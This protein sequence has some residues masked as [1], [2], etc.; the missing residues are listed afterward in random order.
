MR[1]E[2]EPTFLFYGLTPTPIDEAKR[3]LEIPNCAT[4]IGLRDKAILEVFY[5]SGIR[6]EEMTR[7][8]LADVDS[9]NGFLRVNQGK[10]AKDRVVPLGQSA[11]DCV[12]RYI[13]Q[14]R[15]QWSPPPRN[16]KAL[17]LSSRQPH[18]PLKSQVIE[19]MVRQLGRQAG[20][21][22]RVTPHL[23]RHT[24]ATHLVSSG[25]NVAYVQRLLGHSSLRTTQVYV[26]TT[27]PE[28][29]A[30]LDVAHPRN[31]EIPT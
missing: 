30:T 14:V 20:I 23:W 21:S 3:V 5:S 26:R 13:E 19:V 2:H 4:G 9:T 6:L 17:W 28:I 24:C 7:L 16:Q 25:A 10:F 22:K 15:D 12:R 18:E 8:T 1:D 11:S 29:K 27:I 31:Q